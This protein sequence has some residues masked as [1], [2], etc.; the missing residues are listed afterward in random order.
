MSLNTAQLKEDLKVVYT[1]TYE[2]AGSRD[3]ALEAFLDALC[4]K[5]E[6]YVKTATVNYIEGLTAGPYPVTGVINGG[7]E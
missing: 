5:L 7:L 6:V 1:A 4:D 3:A 2:S